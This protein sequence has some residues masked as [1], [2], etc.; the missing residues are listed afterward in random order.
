[1]KECFCKSGMS[2]VTPHIFLG[3]GVGS[4]MK[5]VNTL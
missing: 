1:M 4:L 5:R 3:L 2:F